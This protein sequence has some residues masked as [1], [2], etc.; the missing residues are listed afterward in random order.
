MQAIE[1]CKNVIESIKANNIDE[2]NNIRRLFT[3]RNGA[4]FKDLSDFIKERIYGEDPDPLRNVLPELIEYTYTNSW[5]TWALKQ[6]DKKSVYVPIKL[7]SFPTNAM[8]EMLRLFASS[9]ID[10]GLLC[11]VATIITLMFAWNISDQDFANPKYPL[12]DDINKLVVCCSGKTTLDA[13]KIISKFR[14]DAS[15]FEYKGDRLVKSDKVIQIFGELETDL[16]P[17]RRDD[18]NTSHPVI[19]P[20]TNNLGR[21]SKVIIIPMLKPST[22][23]KGVPDLLQ[24]QSEQVEKTNG[25]TIMPKS[26]T[27]TPIVIPS[28]APVEP[29]SKH[30]DLICGPN[31][32][33]VK[34]N[35]LKHLNNAKLRKNR[36]TE[37]MQEA[38]ELIAKIKENDN[39]EDNRSKLVECINYYTHQEVFKANSSIE[40]LDKGF[41]RLKDY[42]KQIDADIANL[43]RQLNEI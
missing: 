32:Q 3:T 43:E 23:Y 40:K 28:L 25:V 27:S 33:T 29:S 42:G 35:L 8:D 30:V 2:L 9:K 15:P 38:T 10:P 11:D 36:F 4:I 13:T 1:Y 18:A 26:L 31:P 41:A 7:T 37:V 39:N 24:T 17:K 34:R 20:T 16:H 5:S 12:F 22:A 14:C 21:R 6:R 19:C